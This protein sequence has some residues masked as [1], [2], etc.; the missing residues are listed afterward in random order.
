MAPP[1]LWLSFVLVVV[2]VAGCPRRF[3][4]RADEI[5]SQ[6]PAAEAEYRAAQQKFQAGDYAAAGATAQKFAERFGEAEPL[7]PWVRLLEARIAAAGGQLPRARELLT[8]LTDSSDSKLAAAARYELGLVLHRLGDWSATLQ[9]L[10][11]FSGQITDGEAGLELHAVLADAYLQGGRLREGL[12]ELA[13]FYPRARPLEQAYVQSQVRALLPRLSPAEQR[14]ARVR[15]ALSSPETPSESGGRGQRVVGLRAGLVLPLSGKDRALGERVLR[16]VLW[17]ARGG[18]LPSGGQPA[19]LSIEILTRDSGSSPAS[20]AAAVSDLLREGAQA[21]IASPV[22]AE[23][24]AVAKAAAESRIPVLQLASPTP[25]GASGGSPGFHLLFG[26]EE[27]AAR[28]AAWLRTSGLTSVA[29]LAPATPYGQSMTRAFVDALSGTSIQVLAQLSFAANSTTFT[30]QAKQLIELAPQALFVPAT[31]AQLELIAG[32]LAALSGLAT[33]RV[34]KRESE[35]PIRLLLSTVE[36]LG[37]RLLQSSGRYLQGAVLAPVAVAGLP[38]LP[39]ETRFAG[40]APDGGGEPGAL[41]A[42]GFDAVE[43]LRAACLGPTAAA[44]PCSSAQLL[45]NLALISTPGSTGDIAFSSTGQR[46]GQPL[47]VRVE[48]QALRVLR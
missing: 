40:Y 27:R 46:R 44:T 9:L 43:T 35:P 11:P 15:F 4:P 42:I 1:R 21:L 34:E 37:T 20:A 14:E 41:D 26:N 12:A 3:D 36:G 16:G 29:V 25:G 38:L 17:A 39:A 28:L 10:T 19:Q 18:H 8:P 13:L 32:Q 47:L 30:A 23:A 45:T 7:S 22:R 6:N 2:M 33:Q 31:A 5:H 24:A 48:G